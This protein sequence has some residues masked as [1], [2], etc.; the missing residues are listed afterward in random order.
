MKNSTLTNKRAIIFWIISFLTFGIPYFTC[1]LCLFIEEDKYKWVML[2]P[3]VLLF[4]VSLIRTISLLG[5]VSFEGGN[6]VFSK[7][8]CKTQIVS[9]DKV[10][11]IKLKLGDVILSVGRPS[12]D[13]T[14]LAQKVL[15]ITADKTMEVCYSYAMI[16]MLIGI[17]PKELFHI[18]HNPVGKVK[19]KDYR[20][21]QQI[22]GE[23]V[24]KKSKIKYFGQK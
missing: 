12:N 22:F 6:L 16:N 13:A 3:F 9:K 11:A 8:F 2:I 4:L 17:F 10:V 14:F 5:K 15:I 1:Y 20:F 21:L 24:V 23:E 18:I 19:L 7:P